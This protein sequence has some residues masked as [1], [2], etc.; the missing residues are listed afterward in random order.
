MWVKTA[1]DLL[2]ACILLLRMECKCFVKQRRLASDT[3]T[4]LICRGR[5]GFAEVF[6]NISAYDFSINVSEDRYGYQCTVVRNV[7]KNRVGG[8]VIL[9]KEPL[10]GSY[11]GKCTCGV[12]TRDAV[13]CKHMAA[14]VVARGYHSLP[15]RI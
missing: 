10:R 5:V 3:D 12:N 8:K 7:Q 6:S 11:F 14:V 2:N 4:E 13:P 9:L 1:V 15:D